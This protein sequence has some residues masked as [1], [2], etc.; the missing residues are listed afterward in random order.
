MVLR[1]V[2]AIDADALSVADD[3][4]FLTP[5][6]SIINNSDTPNGTIFDY[7]G[8]LG[9]VIELDDTRNTDVFDDDDRFRH[10]ITDGG[11]LIANGTTV[12]SESLIVL[13]ELDSSGSP[14]G[15]EITI[16]VYSQNGQTSNIWAFSV[17]EL[18]ISGRQYVKVSG[19]NNGDSSYYEIAPCFTAGTRIRARDGFKLVEDI[20]PGDKIWTLDN[21]FQEVRWASCTKASGLDEFAPI[22]FSPGSIGNRRSLLVSPNHRILYATP[23]TELLF[24][25]ESVLIPAKYFLDLPGVMRLVV[26]EIEYYHFMFDTHEIVESNECLTESFYPGEMAL[27]GLKQETRSELLTLFPELSQPCATQ[28]VPAAYLLCRYEAVALLTA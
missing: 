22:Q 25:S 6:S 28:R 15:P 7:S 2:F 19:S 9:Q 27:M 13:R 20:L 21:G 24:G 26:P 16:N 4:P 8:G 23:Q 12:E 11:D 10:R 18:L 14:I 3:S 1:N 17:S 5:G